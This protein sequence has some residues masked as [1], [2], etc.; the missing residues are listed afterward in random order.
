MRLFVM[1]RRAVRH[2]AHLGLAALVLLVACGDEAAVPS[3]AQA[4]A[5]GNGATVTV[6]GYVTVAPGAF[7]SAMGDPGFALQDHSGGIYVKITS[8]LTFPLG[9]RVRVT[10]TLAEQAKFR[11]LSAEQASVQQLSGSRTVIPEDVT[12][13][14]VGEA[15]EGTLVR[16]TGRVTKTFL[17]DS[18]Y[19]YK[20][21]VNDGSGEVKIFVHLFPGVPTSTLRALTTAQT[22]QVT[23]LSSQYESTYEVAPR[24]AAD[25]VVK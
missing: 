18:P 23:G 13:G 17:D 22:I 5:Q 2:T 15:T 9:S 10:G 14:G 25:I 24:Q 6:D 19:G 21:W 7:E 12:T 16:V 20:V 3:V 1:V 8:R 4:R 11:I